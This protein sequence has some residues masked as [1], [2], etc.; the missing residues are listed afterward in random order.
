[1]SAS[2]DVS[3]HFQGHIEERYSSAPYIYGLHFW[4]LFTS[5]QLQLHSSLPIFIDVDQRRGNIKG[6]PAS[7][8]W[9][10]ISR[11]TDHFLI[12]IFL[13]Q[14]L[15]QE[16]Y[17]ISFIKFNMASNISIESVDSDVFFVEQ[18]SNE[19]S[20]QRKNSPIILNSTEL[21]LVCFI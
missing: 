15:D 12:F 21:T 7:W 20:P 2:N 9:I 11:N 5:H 14:L 13:I 1:M 8:K 3:M 16:V 4:D 19:P 6:N 10:I 17:S 18:I